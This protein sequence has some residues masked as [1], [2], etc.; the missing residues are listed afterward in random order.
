MPSNK[1]LIG[2]WTDRGR[3][4]TL[5]MYLVAVSD[6]VGL[7]ALGAWLYFTD[8]LTGILIVVVGILGGFAGVWMFGRFR[9]AFEGRHEL[10]VQGVH[11]ETAKQVLG[12]ATADFAPALKS[13][14]GAKISQFPLIK[15]DIDY[16]LPGGLLVGLR[17]MEYERRWM[18]VFSVSPIGDANREFAERIKSRLK[19]E[20]ERAIAPPPP[21]S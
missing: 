17:T 19:T 4:W 20:V 8:P 2:N 18:A 6:F 11:P 14:N 21:S 16:E 7:P 3:S 9:K 12:K 5:I 15:H 1:P 10:W 13:R